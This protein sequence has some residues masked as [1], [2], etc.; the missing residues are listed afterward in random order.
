MVLDPRQVLNLETFEVVEER[1]RWLGE[2]LAE[3]RGQGAVGEV[4]MGPRRQD[5]PMG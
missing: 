2:I 4:R 5:C 3:K 1:S